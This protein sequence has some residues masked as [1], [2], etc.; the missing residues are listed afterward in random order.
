[1]CVC[2]CVFSGS[3]ALRET[4][5]LAKWL[6]FLIVPVPCGLSAIYECSRFYTNSEKVQSTSLHFRTAPLPLLFLLT[7]VIQAER[8][9]E[10]Y[11]DPAS[12]RVLLSYLI[13]CLFTLEAA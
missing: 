12:N 3:L 4:L 1:M 7:K 2:V 8:P 9:I 13:Y 5:R 6:H 10:V 11:P